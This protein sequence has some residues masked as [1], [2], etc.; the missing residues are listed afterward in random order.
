LHALT[1]A[2]RGCACA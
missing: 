2:R 1:S